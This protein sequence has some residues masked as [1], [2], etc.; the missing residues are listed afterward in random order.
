MSS[1]VDSP[2]SF[3]AGGVPATQRDLASG[4]KPMR[5]SWSFRLGKVKGIDIYVHGTFLILLAW[6][7]LSH[8]ING[9]GAA[10]A[11]QGVAFTATIFGIVVLHELGHALAAARYGIGTRDITLYP[12][13]GVASLE[14]IPENPRQEFVVALAGPAVN[15]ALAA[16]IGGVLAIAKLPGGVENVHL[17]GGSFLAKLMW[18]NV[19]LA[20]FNLLPAFPMDGGR[21]LRAALAFRMSR[22]RATEIA[23][24]VGQAMA[25]GFGLL[26]MFGNPMLLFIAFFVWTGAQGEASLVRLRALLHD[27]SVRQ[28]MIRESL[29]LDPSARISDVID[30]IVTRGHHAFPV[31]RDGRIVGVVTKNSVLEALAEVGPDSSVLAAMDERFELAD[32]SETLEGAL[33]RLEARGGGALVVVRDGSLLGVVTPHSVGELLTM[34][35][36]AQARV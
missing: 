18:V 3:G 8:V 23:A 2:L 14:R 34:R 19:S 6:I 4:P 21:V 28:A 22:D 24:R 35:Q 26:G 31:V 12:I 29:V 1:H 10:A 5:T 15:V 9:H 7:G 33:A 25:F 32:P 16:L 13:G 36:A 30:A 27:V 11:L 17:I 20:L